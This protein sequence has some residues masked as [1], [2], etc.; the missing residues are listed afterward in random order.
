MIWPLVILGLSILGGQSKSGPAPSSRKVTPPTP[1]Q[2]QPD[3]ATV[4]PAEDAASA[5][6]ALKAYLDSGGKF[7]TQRARSAE[8][9]R[10]QVAMGVT[11]EDGIVGPK[12]RKAARALGVT[13]PLRKRGQ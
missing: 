12:T 10:A 13:L 1:P 2:R 5:A 7:G 3:L 4:T 8:V 11:G 6:R 9:R